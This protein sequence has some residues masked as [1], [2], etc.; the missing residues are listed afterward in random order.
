MHT[1]PGSWICEHRQRHWLDQW[2]TWRKSDYRATRDRQRKNQVIRT[3]AQQ[4]IQYQLANTR[5]RKRKQSTIYEQAQQ[6]VLTSRT[7]YIFGYKLIPEKWNM[8]KNT[9]YLTSRKK[10]Y[11]YTVLFPILCSLSSPLHFTLK[12]K[13]RTYV[14]NMIYKLFWRMYREYSNTKTPLTI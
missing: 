5:K 13:Q 11:C 14:Q 10:F 8:S 3:K 4:S 1:V 2:K 9:K 12:K 7:Y 6:Q